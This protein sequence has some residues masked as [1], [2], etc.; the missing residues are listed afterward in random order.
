MRLPK[1]FGGG[2]LIFTKAPSGKEKVAIEQMPTAII[3]VIEEN[4]DIRDLF[5]DVL[6]DAGYDVRTAA[7]PLQSSSCIA[8]ARPDLLLLDLA[9]RN[10]VQTLLLVEQLR[11]RPDTAPL[12]IL[13]SATNPHLFDGLETSLRRLGCATLCKP[14]E[15][16]CLLAKVSQHLRPHQ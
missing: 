6:T 10:V 4:A 13:M 14:F 1:L 16:D 9:P 5:A 3:F 15:L 7:Q 2:A 8:D 11:Q 12:P